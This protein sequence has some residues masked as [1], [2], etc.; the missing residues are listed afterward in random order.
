MKKF[1]LLF[2][3]V[4]FLGSCTDLG[5]S[6]EDAIKDMLPRDFKWETYAEINNDVKVSQ[7]VFKIR[8]EIEEKRVA[9]EETAALFAPKVRENCAEILKED[10]GF[11]KQIYVDYAGCPEQGWDRSK[12]CTGKYANSGYATDSSCFIGACWHGGWNDLGA[13]APD[14]D[15]ERCDNDM[16]YY[17]D[18]KNKCDEAK[19]IVILES[20]LSD[21]LN[22]YKNQGI[23][24][25]IK[26]DTTIALMCNFVPW[27]E[28]AAAAK[29][30]LESLAL[31]SNIDSKLI[32]RHYAEFGRND[33]KP[34][35]YCKDG[36]V[37]EER[38]RDKHA[39]RQQASGSTS[40][41]Y[42]YS[43]YLFCLGKSDEKIYVTEE[44]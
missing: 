27:A 33:G 14:V 6:E 36:H 23:R 7:V 18:N 8:A 22:S 40:Y 25:G 5:V 9:E 1:L 28:N 37:G 3:A 15:V 29:S 17:F 35:K 41:Y 16:D 32:E 24:R 21:S 30:H 12:T 39:N 26:S 4:L 2:S 34:Y 31:N 42:D 44:E 11:A 38:N 20:F 19:Q 13:A 10:L 43:A